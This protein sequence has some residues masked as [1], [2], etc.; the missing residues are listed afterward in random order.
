MCRRKPHV[1]NWPGRKDAFAFWNEAIFRSL[2]P[3]PSLH[4]VLVSRNGQSSNFSKAFLF[5]RPQTILDSDSR[6]PLSLQQLIFVFYFPSVLMSINRG[7]VFLLIPLFAIELGAQAAGAGTVFA[8][9]GVGVVASDVPTGF[10]IGRF[11]EKKL[12]LVGLLFAALAGMVA[13]GT[14][15]LILLGGVTFVFGVGKGIWVL[16]RLNYLTEMI[17]HSQ[18]GRAMSGLGGAERIGFFV[19]PIF[20][21]ILTK[22]FG[23]PA[24]FMLTSLIALVVFA[25]VLYALPQKRKTSPPASHKILTLLPRILARHKK[26]FLTAGMAAV[27]LQFIRAGRQLLFPLWG[28]SIGLDEAEIGWVYGLSFAVDMSLF[29]VAGVVMDRFGRKWSAIPCMFILSLSLCLLPLSDTFA[30]FFLVGVLAGLG[31][32]LGSGI[33]MT[34][35]GD[36]SPST[37]RSEFL[38]VW[39]LVGDVGGALGPLMIGL[40]SK[41]FI[42]GTASMATGGIGLL[43]VGLVAFFVKETR[44]PPKNPSR[45]PRKNI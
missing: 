16:A 24:T 15:S 45:P 40:L 1:P 42:L 3:I 35:G 13:G 34:L 25:W 33:L 5:C 22:Y 4:L 32:G 9:L 14:H 10:A 8:L 41:I 11:G 17:P 21:G 26:V 36:L 7:M 38:G 2:R 18:R 37:E 28:K 6:N 20:G 39:R 31:N 29:Y 44:N 12:M 19:G 30:L 27:V 43:G 23:Y